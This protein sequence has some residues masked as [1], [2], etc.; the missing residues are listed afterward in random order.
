MEPRQQAAMHQL[1]A[2]PGVVGGMV[3]DPAGKV[4]GSA[5]PAV[6]DPAGLA[7]LAGQLSADGYFQDWLSGEQASLDLRFGD[8]R[9]VVR[10]LDSQWL[11][12]LCT[13]QTNPQLLSMS[14]TQVVRRLRASGEAHTGEFAVPS[15]APA[16]PAAPTALDRLRALASAELGAHAGQALEILAAAGPGAKG[17]L[18]ATAD[19]E[20]M[21]RLFISKKKAEE[22]GQRMRE[23]L[24]GT[25]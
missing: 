12:V 2:V 4:I 1:A 17:L 20:K 21:T 22:I 11:L 7:Q 5:F 6:F 3:F 19:I 9:V 18:A 10:G 24:V 13:P 15:A 25:T 14:L 23:L 16:A 8:G